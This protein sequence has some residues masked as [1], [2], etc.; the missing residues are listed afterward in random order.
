MNERI[1]FVDDEPEML[2]SLR[3]A[4]HAEQAYWTLEFLDCPFA[5][6]QRMLETDVDLLVC[7]VR[8]PG[9]NGLDLLEQ[10]RHTEK[11]REIPVIMV[12]ALQDRCLKRCALDLGAADLLNKPFDHQDLRARIR[13][14]LRLAAVHK[15]M[16]RHNEVLRQRVAEKTA[17]LADSRTEIIWRLAKAA[18]Y[19]DDDTGHH[20]LRVASYSRTIAEAMG[21]DRS[22][23]EMLF[24][25]SPLHDIGKI[26]IPDSILLK[27]GKLTP[28][29]WEVM[30]QH[31][32][33]GADILREDSAAR[34]LY[35]AWRGCDASTMIED[36]VLKAAWTIALTHHERWNGSGYPH[37]LSGE[38]IPLES[39]IVALS[40]AFDA[41]RSARPYKL[42][43]PEDKTL[44][45]I[46]ENVGTQFDG[47]VFAAFERSLNDIRDIH[48]QFEDRAVV[49]EGVAV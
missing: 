37:G 15:Q 36:P 32:S 12:T 22:F 27:P 40:D 16:Q 26:G 31:C 11:L 41:L 42:A 7:D 33:I 28:V 8:M 9:W 48:R 21:A 17:Q 46:R 1:L 49:S 38:Q 47:E 18:E 13:S 25:T 23:T 43:Y 14:A 39:R 5:A 34:P 29:E 30:K 44:A 35:Q 4:L 24:L 19:R 45:I 2:D 6:W 3:R 10:M 20:I